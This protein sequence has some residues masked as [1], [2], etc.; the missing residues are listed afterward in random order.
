[1]REV[2]EHV[3]AL[4]REGRLLAEAARSA[5]PGAPVP[6]CP[7]WKVADLLLHTAGVHRWAADIVSRALSEPEYDDSYFRSGPRDERAVDEYVEAHS[8]LCTALAAAPAGLSCFT[9]L[10]APSDLAFWARRQCHEASIHRADADAAAGIATS[11][12]PK[13]AADGIDE[14]LTCFVPRPRSRLRSEKPWSMAVTTTDTG[15]AW[16]VAVSSEPPVTTQ[17][18]DAAAEC[19]V[20]GTASDLYLLLWNRRRSDGMVIE[21]DPGL[22]AQWTE[23]VTVRWG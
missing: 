19:T 3:A 21:G 6:T 13:H 1:M 10:P 17:G 23:Q 22:L 11:Y 18:A 2:A 12:E 5:G 20:S 7:D 4:A 14:L 16:T 15:D 8:A 9:F